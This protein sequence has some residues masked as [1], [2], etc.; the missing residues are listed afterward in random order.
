MNDFALFDE[1][2]YQQYKELKNKE[3]HEDTYGCLLAIA[4]YVGIGFLIYHTTDFK[5]DNLIPILL[6]PY[7][8][9]IYGVLIHIFKIDR[10]FFVTFRFFIRKT[11]LYRTLEQLKRRY[12]SQEKRIATNIEKLFGESTSY[13]KAHLLADN[14]EYLRYTERAYKTIGSAYPV[15]SSD[16]KEAREII[17]SRINS[18]KAKEQSQK[19]DYSQSSL[20]GSTPTELTSRPKPSRQ[21]NQSGLKGLSTVPPEPKK[22]SKPIYSKLTNWRR[23][24]LL[25]LEVGE[26]GETLV[27]QYEQN[28]LEEIGLGHLV[29]RIEHSSKTVGDGL[30]Y[31]IKSF[32]D[33]SEPIYIEVKTTIGGF[34]S[35]LI[36]TRNELDFMRQYSSHY[37]LYRVYH[38]DQQTESGELYTI[39]G[40]PEIRDHFDFAPQTF[41]AK[42]RHS[43]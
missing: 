7:V 2:Q 28:R 33:R 1:V 39:E 35:N 17:V 20:I 13:R 23:V 36:F 26:M 41:V 19:A 15:L 5:G 18:N 40:Y 27:L 25:R 21:T 31:D 22:Q 8:W 43:N 34:W 29:D 32:N 12:L 10:I 14:I 4:F 11:T 9:M 38:L 42:P 16:I 30:G 37:V 6:I 24:N 3:Y